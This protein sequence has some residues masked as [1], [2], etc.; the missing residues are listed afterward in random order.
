MSRAAQTRTRTFF[1]TAINAFRQCPERYYLKYIRKRKRPMPFSR[2][3]ITGSAAH[4]LVA[5]VLP[6]FMQTGEIPVDIAPR[7]L[8]EVST[9]EYPA[10]EL[11]YRDQDAASVAACTTA[12]LDMIPAGSSSLLQER[13]LYAPLGRSGVQVGARIDLVLRRD[14]GDIEHID[15]KTGK[16][17]DDAIQNL[18]ARAVVGR[19]FGI[20]QRI[21]TTTLYLQHRHTQSTILDRRTGRRDWKAI[22]RDIRDIRSLDD[23]PPRPG[24]LCDYCPY[25]ARDCTAWLATEGSQREEADL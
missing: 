24:P 23:F 13:N 4:R 5:E 22:A 20:Q 12:A 21:R 10:D 18:I 3:L 25:Q 19:K 8:R 14:N 11:S 2:P 9:T 1:P 16:I 17:R 15:F 6:D 7:A